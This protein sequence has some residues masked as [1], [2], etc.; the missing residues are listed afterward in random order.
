M[1]DTLAHAEAVRVAAV[2]RSDPLTRLRQALELSD[3]VRR[4]ALARLRVVH[5]GRS[6]RE[7]AK[8]LPGA[9]LAGADRPR[10]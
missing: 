6:D 3:L 5:P 7:L 8:L 10:R 4:L 9:S 2:R 1:R